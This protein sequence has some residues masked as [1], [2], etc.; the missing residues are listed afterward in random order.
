MFTW[1][2][3]NVVMPIVVFVCYIIARILIGKPFDE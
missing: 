3:E 2:Y 1:L